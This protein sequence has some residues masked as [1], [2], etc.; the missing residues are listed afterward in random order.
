MMS[1]IKKI[2]LPAI[3]V[4]VVITVW[5]FTKPFN[6]NIGLIEYVDP[7]IGSGGHGHVFVGA[8]VPFG[9]V[10]VGPTNFNKGWDWSSSYHHTDSIVKGFC[11]LNVSGTGMSDLGELTIMPA[12]GELKYNA[13]NQD[14][15]MSGYSSLYRKKTEI[16]TV[17]YYKVELERYDI[18]VELTASERVGFHR[19]TYPSSKK[20]R[21]IID[22][23]EGS[24]DRPT[25]TYLKKVNDTTF[26][27]Y[28][29]SSGWASDQREYFTLIISKPVKDF[30]L[31]DRNKKYK[32]NELKGIYVK[33]FLEFETDK[34]EEIY[35][36]MGVST[37]SSENAL[38]NMIVEIPHWDFD[39]VKKSA[40]NKW[41]QELSKINIKTEDLKRKRVFYTAMYHTMI[42]PNLYQDVNG[43]YRGTDKVVY[44][45]TTFTNYTLFSLWD[46]YRA[47]HPLYTIT[48][49]ERVSDMVN[50]ML[51][52][53][54]HQGKLPI[55]HLRGNETNTMPGYSAI[56]VV[57]D[58]SLKGFEGIDLEKV[59]EAVKTSAT[60]DFEP[61]VKKLM[62]LGYIP[63]DYMVESVASSMEY[64]I[65]DWAIAQLAKKLNKQEDY[66]YFLNRSKAYKEYFDKETRFMRGKLTDGSWRTPF[67]P[68][69]AEHRVNDYCEGNA[70][71]YLWLV[72][73]D[74]EG[75]IDLLGGDEKYTQKLDELFSMSSDLGEGAHE[76][77][78]DITG[79]V[80]QY[81]HGNEPSHHTTYMYAYSGQQY[82]IADKVR[83]INNELYTDKPD[84]LSGN[85]DCGQMSAWHI[86]SS[87]GFYP[88]NPSNGA[89]VF[90]SPLFDEA[91]IGLPENKKFT[92]IA[93]QNSD[94]NIYI[95]S[96]QLNG[97]DYKFSYITH[98]DIMQGGEI[99]F[100][101][102]PKP[103]MNFG[104]EKEFRPQ[105][106]VY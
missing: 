8:T 45:D 7:F 51:K 16:N 100:N 93:N 62:E 90:G 17:G 26:Q 19:Y 15:H 50:S 30:I 48:H 72:P 105:S 73:Q 71:Q 60:G 41:N 106:I 75:L 44:K 32:G 12:T 28:R 38:E 76:T 52:I 101:M 86:F 11:H 68:V 63:G 10:Q 34:N 42:A 39:M 55:W 37:V 61:G 56:P 27:G 9:G 33:G 6:S 43:E 54:D 64:A 1:L 14:N 82:K 103:N 35:V 47:A 102:G 87:L 67:D 31:Y 2:S 4:L 58:A 80:G 88:V 89:Y 85:E 3:L 81:A 66:E 57:I 46:T 69:R 95:Q 49:P 99:I 36:K 91:S 59:F 65:A 94:D 74:P 84:G 18:D 13:G 21:V 104:K 70:W 40:E 23:G 20:S 92:I 77:S 97:K 98:K 53:F 96:V 78:M 79:L 83:Y 29:F 24:A 5:S 25:E 22:L